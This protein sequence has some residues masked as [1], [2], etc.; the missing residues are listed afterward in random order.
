VDQVTIAL[1][2]V[3]DRRRW[4]R[5]TMSLR[6]CDPGDC[7]LSYRDPF[8]WNLE[9]ADRLSAA[10]GWHDWEDVVRGAI[11]YVWRP[12]AV[13]GVRITE[14]QGVLGLEDREGLALACT[15]ALRRLVGEAL[16]DLEDREWRERSAP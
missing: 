5:V 10:Y 13:G 4:V 9:P 14:V 8:A 6:P 2:R 11:E 12:Y 16:A 7:F 1:E 3:G 15:L